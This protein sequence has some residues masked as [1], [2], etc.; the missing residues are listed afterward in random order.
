VHLCGIFE[1]G[2]PTA[3]AKGSAGLLALVRELAPTIMP[4]S[5]QAIGSIPGD[6]ID[7]SARSGTERRA[8]RCHRAESNV[9]P[10]LS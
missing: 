1:P 7:E 3:D 9:H 5:R 8:A 10:E 4:L 6:G 2:H